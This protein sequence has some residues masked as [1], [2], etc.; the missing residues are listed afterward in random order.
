[1]AADR[2]PDHVLDERL[3]AA[4]ELAQSVAAVS[5]DEVRRVQ[6]LGEDQDDRL[7]RE[8]LEERVRALGGARAGLV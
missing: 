7:D 6:A 1:M 3:R 8:G 5:A 4:G 2:T